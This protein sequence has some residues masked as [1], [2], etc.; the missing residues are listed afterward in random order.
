[1]PADD[2]RKI[3]AMAGQ[4]YRGELSFE[5]L[6]QAAPAKGADEEISE[7][8]DLIEHEPKRGGFLGASESDYAAHTARIEALTRKLSASR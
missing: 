8:I 6:M 5:I 7:L 1:L 2:R 4:F 3:A